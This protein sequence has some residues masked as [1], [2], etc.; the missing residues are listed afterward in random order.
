MK[1]TFDSNV[2]QQV[3]N[4][5]NYPDD[6]ASACFQKISEAIS[7]GKINAYLAETTFTLE[8]FKKTDRQSSLASY[9][10]KIEFTTDEMPNG[11]IKVGFKIDPDKGAHPGNNSYLSEYLAKAIPLG[12][13]ILHCPR[14]GGFKNPDIQDEYFARQTEAETHDRN[15]L[16]G[17]VS[18]AIEARNAGVS[19]IKKIGAQYSPD[20]KDWLKGIRA[21]PDSEEKAIAKAFSEWVDGD[22][23]AVHVGYKN[24]HYCTRDQGKNAGQGSVLAKSNREWLEQTYGVVFVTPEELYALLA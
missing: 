1:V 8:A 11:V 13:K 6:P 21:A 3:S 4:P 22:S 10:P 9:S 19:H 2:W 18:R 14:I 7:T 23:V 5:S 16:A 17:E 15:E 20:P 12:F 24:T